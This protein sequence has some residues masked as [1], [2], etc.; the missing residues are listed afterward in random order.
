LQVDEPLMTPRTS[1][2]PPSASRGNMNLHLSQRISAIGA[3]PYC[4]SRFESRQIAVIR[5]L[6]RG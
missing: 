5:N 6:L 1:R 4:A 2:H 3:D